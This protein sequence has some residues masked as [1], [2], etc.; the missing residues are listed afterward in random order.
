AMRIPDGEHNADCHEEA[1]ERRSTPRRKPQPRRTD[2]CRG[3]L[4][5]NNFSQPPHRHDEP[6]TTA[7]QC[8]YVTG[9]VGI[10]VESSTNLLDAKVQAVLVIYKSFASPDFFS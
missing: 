7:G 9:S 2:R 8:F 6:I 10:V 1:K 3:G 4:H 5:R